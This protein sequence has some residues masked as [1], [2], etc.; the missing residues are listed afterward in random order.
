[1]KK[2]IETA[3]QTLATKG[4]EARESAL[5]GYYRKAKRQGSGDHPFFLGQAIAHM[6]ELNGDTRP[7]NNDH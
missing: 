6:A 7:T 3:R 5:K 1:M 4:L 2:A